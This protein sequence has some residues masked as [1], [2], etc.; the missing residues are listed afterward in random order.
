MAITIVQRLPKKI[1]ANDRMKIIVPGGAK[2]RNPAI[3]RAAM[4]FGLFMFVP[5]RY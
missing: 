1:I 2:A 4:R 5:W 3:K